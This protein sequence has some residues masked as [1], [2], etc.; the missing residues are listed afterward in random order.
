MVK[1]K[2]IILFFVII[3]VLIN[4]IILNNSRCSINNFLKTSKDFSINHATFSCKKLYKNYLYNFSKKIFIGTF[5]E[6]PLRKI[7]ENKHGLQ[8]PLLKNKNFQSK[9]IN[10]INL[11]I[12]K[13]ENIS[14][15]EIE[16]YLKND[17]KNNEETNTWIRS[18]GGYKNLKFNNSNKNIDINNIK[19]LKLF[20]KYQTL[21]YKKNP[22]NWVQNI[23]INPIF[24]DKKIIFIS[25]DYNINAIN[26][27][28][29]KL[30]W[31]KKFLLQPT[32]RGL[33]ASKEDD[34]TYIYMTIGNSLV[35][36]NVK[37]GNLV[38]SFG[39][40]GF[41]NNVSTLT[42]PVIFNKEI[43]I[44]SFSSIRIYD[45]KSGKF[46]SKIDI[47]PKNKNFSQ[48]G[49]VWGG[50]A[51]DKKNK[52][53][54]LPTGNPRPALIGINR[55]GENKN[56]NS[57]V[58]VDIEKRKIKWVFQDV[59]HDLW[60][61]DVSSP[62]ILT[63]FK[64]GNKYLEVVIITTKTGNVH[65][66]E[67]STGHSFFKITYEKAP[68]SKIFGEITSD[69]QIKQKNPKGLIN[70]EFNP[71]NLSSENKND[72]KIV[73]DL[74][75]A[76]YGWFEPPSYGKKLI[77]NGIHGG[78][79]WPGSALNPNKNL[80][81]T[82]LNDY[83]F[84]MLVEGK[85]TS[86]LRPV[87]NFLNLYDKKCASCHG[88]KRNGIFDPTIKKKIEFIEKVKIKNDKVIEGYIPSLI[89]HS[90]FGNNNLD[91]IFSSK[92]FG[93]YHKKKLINNEEITG[94]KKLF[95][96]WD[97]L[98]LNNNVIQ[99]RHHWAKFV[100]KNNFPPT[101][102][103]W[104]KIIALNLLNGEKIWETK[105]GKL[106][107]NEDINQMTGTINYGGV[108]LTGGDVLFFT[109]TPDNYVYALNANN[110]EV[111]WSFKMEAAGSAPPIIYEIDGKQFVSIISTG[112]LFNEFKQKGSSLYTFNLE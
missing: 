19:N 41:V 97:N 61:F 77:I 58:V 34:G 109:G 107:K 103:P 42:P 16:K 92:K 105:V 43:F 40:N 59:I 31:S 73:M 112:G 55:R 26:P 82:P 48:G 27:L 7:R 68:K 108:A 100:N 70:I 3:I 95:I 11:D 101:K 93:F 69:Y 65:I 33:T 99:L 66:L 22:K 25:A 91:E 46:I 104:G 32:R 5:L 74:E 21:D 62:P 12:N 45:L 76:T 2:K 20:W 87:D 53:L 35:K 86:R 13:I 24:I 60:D 67:R 75:R 49:V 52:L 71:K 85:T 38:K 47:H 9:K 1:I 29:G 81:F 79:T 10:Q 4:L 110:G 23:E 51:F 64:F 57:L 44:V 90:L 6:I 54:F 15:S 8:Y 96:K 37:N 88:K 94:L 39:K 17:F 89:G 56:A 78:A 14:F 63:E 36:L 28:T 72:P 98:L 102:A 50:N 111:I 106:S 30:V 84:Y 18:N 83:P 80:M